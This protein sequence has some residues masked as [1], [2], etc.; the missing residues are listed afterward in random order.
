[1]V[2]FKRHTMNRD[3]WKEL[4]KEIVE[5]GI[6]ESGRE[7]ELEVVKAA[8]GDKEDRKEAAKKIGVG[9]VARF[10][11]FFFGWM[12]SKKKEDE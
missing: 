12:M 6:K 2:F 1:M 3:D 8:T 9:L 7:V 10:I 5:E 4:G 11:N